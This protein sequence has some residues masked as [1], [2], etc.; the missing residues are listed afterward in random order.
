MSSALVTSF[1]CLIKQQS[2]N[3]SDGYRMFCSVV[4]VQKEEAWL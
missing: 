1:L 2:E 4:R 3:K